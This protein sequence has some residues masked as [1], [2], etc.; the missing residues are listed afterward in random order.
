[1][2][3]AGQVARDLYPAIGVHREVLAGIID[4][5]P[6]KVGQS[7]AGLPV[8]SFDQ[9]VEAGVRAVIIT[10]REELQDVIWA[11]R[12]RLLRAG[13]Q[14][15]WVPARYPS[16]TW[17]DCLI[18]QYEWSLAQTRGIDLVYLNDYPSRE[19]ELPG[20]FMPHVREAVRAG[21]TICEIGSGTGLCTEPMIETAGTYYAVDFS[22][23]LL[24]EALEHRFGRYLDKLHTCHDQTAMLAGV[25]DA[26]VDLVF[27]YN[28]FVHFKSDLVHRFLTAIRRVLKPGGR[29]LL[30]F[31]HWNAD[32][33]RSWQEH[34][35]AKFVGQHGPMYY[36]HPDQ[37]AA[38]AESLGLQFDVIGEQGSQHY[39]GRFTR[40]EGG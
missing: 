3:G 27:S 32:T 8:I 35:Q 4:D 7:L 11:Q 5:D 36:N 17:D 10:V 38:S 31:L 1:L 22:A 40:P 37:L 6:A 34:E 9:A 28:V 33:I 26:A 2:Y 18:E 39:A 20:W 30:H 12:D 23:R 15:L 13:M 24:Y 16:R 19:P 25:P 14:V 21:A 29:A